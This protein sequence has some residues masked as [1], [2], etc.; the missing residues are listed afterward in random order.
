[1]ADRGEH[2]R[3]S[4][5]VAGFAVSTAVT[6]TTTVEREMRSPVPLTHSGEIVRFTDK[7][8]VAAIRPFDR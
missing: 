2:L 8:V 1:M 6:P 7:S 5:R 3:S 4:A